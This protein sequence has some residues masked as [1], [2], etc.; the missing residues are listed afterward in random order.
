MSNLP[1]YQTKVPADMAI[2]IISIEMVSFCEVD[3][4]FHFFYAAALPT[5]N[6]STQLIHFLFF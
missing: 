5:L 4:D 1:Y 2:I 3:V 6:C